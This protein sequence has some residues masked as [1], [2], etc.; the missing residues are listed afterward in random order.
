MKA[1]ASVPKTCRATVRAIVYPGASEG[2]N[3]ELYEA[4]SPTAY[5]A[6][7]LVR[8]KLS[9]AMPPCWSTAIPLSRAIWSRGRVSVWGGGTLG[10]VVSGGVGQRLIMLWVR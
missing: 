2:Y 4:Q 6:E 7:V 8:Q 9:I 5:T 3:R 10:V 1:P